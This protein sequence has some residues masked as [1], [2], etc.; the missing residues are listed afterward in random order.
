MHA[1]DPQTDEVRR[2]S[3]SAGNVVTPDGVAEIHG[4]DALRIYLLFM[5]P[6]ENNTVW[7]EEGIVGARRFLERTWRLASAVAGTAP[8]TGEGGDL[9]RTVHRTIRRVSQEI[10]VFKFNTG[11]AA[12]MEALNELAD[13]HRE[14][15]ATGELATAVRTFV[16]LLAPFAPHVAEEMWEQLGGTYSVHQQPWPAW[17]EAL[18][19]QERVTLAVQV[20][21]RVRDRLTVAA[22]TEEAQVRQRA[23]ACE[24]VRRHLEGRQVTRVIYVPGRLVNLVTRASPS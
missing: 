14:H 20:D 11:I 8:A 7:E 2:M 6:F 4:A 17:D 3:K 21:G 5:A 12:L 13:H 1:R 10:E 23:L 19:A 24:N 15:G 9:Q 22:D 18:V 16:L